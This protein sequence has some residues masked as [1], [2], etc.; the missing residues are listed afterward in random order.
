M[1]IK[2]MPWEFPFLRILTGWCTGWKRLS[3]N[4]KEY[5]GTTFEAMRAGERYDL[6][7]DAAGPMTSR[8]SKSKAKNALSPSGAY[9]NVEMTRKD[10]VQDLVFLKELIEAGKLKAVIDRRYPL[11]Q[12]AEAHRYVEAGHKKGNVVI[13]VG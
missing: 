8:V 13:T 1:P 12:T 3:E 7:F 5:A 4:R 11:E 9:V 10:R 2:R 6:I